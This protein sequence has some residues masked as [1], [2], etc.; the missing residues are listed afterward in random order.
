MEI[1]NWIN[2]PPCFECRQLFFVAP[3]VLLSAVILRHTHTVVHTRWMRSWNMLG[4]FFFSWRFCFRIHNQLF[5]AVAHSR[6]HEYGYWFIYC[7]KRSIRALATQNNICRNVCENDVCFGAHH[8]HYKQLEDS[9]GTLKFLIEW[10]RWN[11]AF[12]H[13]RIHYLFMLNCVCCRCVLCS[14]LCIYN[15]LY[16]IC[17]V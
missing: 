12:I 16:V 13:I 7:G 2:L 8:Q 6:V 5:R 11:Y 17:V 3:A 15:T 14:G 9:N 4:V 1:L 10:C